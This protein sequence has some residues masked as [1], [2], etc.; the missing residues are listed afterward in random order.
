MEWINILQHSDSVEYCIVS[1]NYIR[2]L[3]ISY[4]IP[5]IVK[6]LCRVHTLSTCSWYCLSRSLSGWASPSVG[7]H[8]LC[9]RKNAIYLIVLCTSYLLFPIGFM[10]LSLGMYL[11]LLF[12][13][14]S[15][16]RIFGKF[17]DLLKEMH[18]LYVE[19]LNFAYDIYYPLFFLLICSIWSLFY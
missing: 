13:I 12:A 4:F 10:G 18:F 16:S 1:Y 14:I 5:G 9:G 3:N 19:H 6:H 11:I 8:I 17:V 15:V 2:I 7:F